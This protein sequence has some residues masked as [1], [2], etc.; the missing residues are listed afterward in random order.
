MRLPSTCLLV[1]LVLRSSPLSAASAPEDPVLQALIEEALGGNPGLA[2]ARQAVLAARA[3]PD[4]AESRPGPKAGVFYQND[5]WSPSLGRGEMTLLGFS[6]G[7]ELP[8]PGKLDL[9]RRIAESDVTAASA[10]LE[11][12]RLGLID[13]SGGRTTGLSWR[14]A[15][16]SWPRN[17]GR[18]G[19]RSRRRRGRGTHPPSDLQQELLRAQVEATRLNGVHIQHHAEARARLAEL[20]ALRGRPAE[21]PVERPRG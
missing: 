17:I 6:A 19:G 10:E 21:T 18:S 11:R 7:Q 1:F 14:G 20:N 15:S 16:R 12:S 13:P 5:G 8:Y 4:Q 3:R 9:R 2:A